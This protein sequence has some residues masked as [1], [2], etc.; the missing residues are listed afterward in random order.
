[1]CQ[2][3][4]HQPHHTP[5]HRP[6]GAGLKVPFGLRDGKLLRPEQVEAGLACRCLCPACA[7]PLLAK[8]ASS[9]HRRPHFAHMADTDCRAGYETALHLKAKE[10]ISQHARLWLPA[11]D[12][13][14]DM[15]NPPALRD[16]EGRLVQGRRVEFPGREA[17]LSEVRLEVGC[18]DYVPDI[19]AKDE[20]GELLIEI[21]VSHAVDE[22]KRR[23]I[24][25]EGRRL[26]EIDLSR[27]D[28]VI[29]SD[30]D[31][32]LHAVLEDP[33]R[34][35][36][37]SCPEAT[38]AWRE[39][40]RDLKHEMASRN[41]EI[42]RK[43]EPIE[44]TIRSQHLAHARGIATEQARKAN[45]ERF[46]E[47]ERAPHR[48]A[49]EVLPELVS[50]ERIEALMEA[51]EKRDRQAIAELL[52]GLPDPAIRRELQLAGPNSWVYTV[53]PAYWQS[54]VYRH[55]V[56]ARASGEQFNQ[57][58]VARW[59]MQR[60]G[61]EE[62]LYSLFRAQYAFRSRARAA[63]IRKRTISFWA[64][65]ELE[66]QQIPDFYRPINSFIDRLI[67]LG[68]LERVPD[69]LGQVQVVTE[70]PCS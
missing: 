27:L 34:R 52:D 16:D 31:L 15:P 59:V 67:Y 45:R 49:L 47:Q 64:F 29:V 39:A 1:M 65:T 56:F 60:F 38:D 18:G 11:W 8:A 40:Y 33:A 6:N 37:L 12:G 13:D 42:A 69:I 51:Y 22:L 58:D 21:R 35:A 63:G 53:H 57:R 46:R 4:S 10:L 25:S 68:V 2:Q 54:A 9:Q 7:A 14:A 26:I 50:M 30:E 28:P 48:Q 24:Q 62:P 41:A 70:N 66:N 20:F 5:V 17:E 3:S 19:L 61:R 55:F 43:R 32:L 44:A 23:R 36:W